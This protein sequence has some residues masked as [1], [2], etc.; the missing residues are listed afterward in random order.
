MPSSVA[1]ESVARESVL[2]SD[3]ISVWCY[4]ELRVVSHQMHKACHGMPFRDALRAGTAAMQRH[5]ALGWLSDDRLNGPL[6]DDDEVWGNS[7]WFPTTKAA[8][9]KYWA[10]VLPQKAVGKLNV[11]RLI[12]G[13]RKRGVEGQMFSDPGL[14]LDWLRVMI[15]AER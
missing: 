5:S 12:E 1:L 2:E 3:Q 6:P 11:K 9:W 8:G 13:V 7:I 10:M 14:A 15:A 4:P